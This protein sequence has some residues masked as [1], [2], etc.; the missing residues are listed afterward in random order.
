M[1]TAQQKAWLD[2]LNDENSVEIYPYDPKALEVF[3]ALKTKIQAAFYEP[4]EVLHRGS[5]SLE[6]AGQGELDIYIPVPIEKMASAGRAIE[7][8]FGPPKSNYAGDR[9]RFVT[10]VGRTKAEIF[11]INERSQSWLDGSAFEEYLKKDYDTLKAYEKLKEQ[12]R[13]LSTRAYYTRKIEFI[14]DVLGKA[15]I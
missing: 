5:T 13:G 9:M 12:S 7:K 1:I 11:V 2:T 15:N 4:I 8:L 6:I 14:N 10:F 3:E